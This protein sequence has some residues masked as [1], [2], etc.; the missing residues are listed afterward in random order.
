M[1]SS[2][3]TSSRLGLDQRLDAEAH[4]LGGQR[5]AAGGR[6]GD[7][8]G[9][10][11]FELEDAARRR[12]VLVRGDAA[13][14]ALVHADRFGDVAQ[15]QRPQMLHA[16]AEEAVLLAHDLGRDLED[17]GGALMQR[18]DQ[19]IG[20]LVAVGEIVALGLAARRAGDL[21]RSSGC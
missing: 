21:R 9:E 10:E 3:S 8:R 14:R 5:R 2:D 4:R 18:L 16:V 12:H 20:L 1:R 15:H 13:H 11:I 17:G 6:G 19:P 7:R